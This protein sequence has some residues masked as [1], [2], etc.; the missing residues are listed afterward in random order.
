MTGGAAPASAGAA[1][2]VT[3]GDWSIVFSGAD[4]CGVDSCGPLAPGVTCCQSSI[5]PERSL[6]G[7]PAGEAAREEL[8]AVPGMS[9]GGRYCS[10]S[11]ASN[12]GDAI[13]ANGRLIS[14]MRRSPAKTVAAVGALVARISAVS[15]VLEQSARKRPTAA[16]GKCSAIR[17]D[18]SRWVTRRVR[19][20]NCQRRSAAPLHVRPQP[21]PAKPLQARH[22]TTRR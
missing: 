10:A 18:I 20:P 2:P 3:G 11:P 5:H 4:G 21:H 9:A 15:A 1:P 13:G 7:V 14:V 17:F 12:R 16:A 8:V 6:P 22:A 19:L